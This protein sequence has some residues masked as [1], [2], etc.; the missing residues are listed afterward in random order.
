MN[1]KTSK[2]IK[3]RLITALA[4]GI[5]FSIV[6]IAFIFIYNKVFINHNLNDLLLQY[7]NLWSF[8][9]VLILISVVGLV[10]IN[11]GIE[12]LKWKYTL[13]NYESISFNKAVEA[14]LSGVTVSIAAPNRTGEFAGRIFH[15]EKLNKV[16]AAILT[17]IGSFSQLLVTIM[18]GA[19]GIGM[20]M[21]FYPEILPASV[22]LYAPI[23][24]LSA[25]ILCVLF[26][27]LNKLPHLFRNKYF[28]RLY[29]FLKILNEFKTQELLNIVAM[30]MI[31]YMV[32]SIQFYL[33]LIISGVDLAFFPGMLLISVIYFI[34]TFI[35]T[36]II[37]ELAVRGSVSVAIL[38]LVSTN[39]LAIV[40]AGF[41]LW[42]IN[43]MIP[44]LLG[45]VFLFKAKLVKSAAIA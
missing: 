16:Q 6:L 28:K 35:P 3:N 11:W 18:A 27:L 31:R 33:L 36:T 40:N 10:G 13:R 8:V 23:V 12:A 5:K 25:I 14:V 45:S 15:L 32:F 9:P 7:E 37:S 29:L 26:F 17:I 43:L 22:I 2:G 41:I 24:F 21:F 20:L 44:A 1:I 4:V 39:T 42:M 30:S 38:G 19:S 34:M